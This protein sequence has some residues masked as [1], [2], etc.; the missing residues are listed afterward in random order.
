M[1]LELSRLLHAIVGDSWMDDLGFY[2]LFNSISVISGR[3]DDD[4][5]RLCA[6]EPRLWLGRF[7]LE[8]GSNPIV[9][10]S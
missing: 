10:D 9:G 6:M 4:N 5:E 2:I 8:R 7:R 3:W 1:Y